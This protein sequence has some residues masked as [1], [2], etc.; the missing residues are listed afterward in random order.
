MNSE[1]YSPLKW[2]AQSDGTP[3]SWWRKCLVIWAF[4]SCPKV[5]RLFLVFL[6]CT[7][8][9]SP[10]LVGATEKRELETARGES[11]SE[12]ASLVT[13]L[14]SETT[15]TLS[16]EVPRDSLL[17]RQALPMEKIILT[18]LLRQLGYPNECIT[19]SLGKCLETHCWEEDSQEIQGW[20]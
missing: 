6:I 4:Q 5:L 9:E 18:W 3:L 20:L 8:W 7:H 11:D 2:G 17:T 13:R 1:L 10:F 12:V 19:P 16:W 15:G 14:S